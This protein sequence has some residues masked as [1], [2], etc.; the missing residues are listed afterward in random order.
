MLR[1]MTFNPT[2]TFMSYYIKNHLQLSQIPLILKTVS[3]PSY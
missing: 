1:N 2:T 3:K